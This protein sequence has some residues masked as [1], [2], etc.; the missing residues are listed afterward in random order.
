MKVE[1]LEKD[2]DMIF[3]NRG[4]D[5]FFIILSEVARPIR[6]SK[7]GER[8]RD[9]TMKHIVSIRV[10]GVSIDEIMHYIDDDRYALI[11]IS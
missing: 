4:K 8:S 2:V 1:V 10:D 11:R 3:K 5:M 9:K 6:Y 7:T